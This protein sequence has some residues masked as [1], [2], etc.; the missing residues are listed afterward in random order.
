MDGASAVTLATIL[1][2]LTEMFTAGVSWL[3][4]VVETVVANPL[5]LFTALIGFIGV[6]IGFYKR[7]MH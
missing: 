1:S 6:G 3:G 2:A 7:L 4:I 5:L